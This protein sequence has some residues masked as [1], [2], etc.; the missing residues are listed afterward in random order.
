MALEVLTK[1]D[2]QKFKIELLEDISNLFQIRT[3][4]QKLWLRTSEVRKMLNMSA[5]TL[6][7]LRIKG[8]LKCSKIGGIIYYDYRDIEKMMNQK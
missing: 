3:T 1:D 4:E 8:Q 6:K 2:L 7:N 5:G